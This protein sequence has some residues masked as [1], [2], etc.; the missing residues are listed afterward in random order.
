[1]IVKLLNEHYLE[2]LSLKGGCRGSSG[3]THVKMPHCWKSHV[4]AQLC[5]SQESHQTFTPLRRAASA[6]LGE[7]LF[8]LCVLTLAV[9][10]VCI[11]SVFH[12]I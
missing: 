2:F 9:H 7:P 12:L 6:R 5:K 8:Q 1:M 3:S 10:E 4:T 11:L